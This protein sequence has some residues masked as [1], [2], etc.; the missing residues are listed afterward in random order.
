MLF[1]AGL[2]CSKQTDIKKRQY[3]RR[4]TPR[5]KLAIEEK[6]AKQATKGRV[7]DLSETKITETVR[8]SP[9]YPPQSAK[10]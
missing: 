7:E 6:Q 9:K 5:T 10:I 3:F 2:F 8:D 1:N 4:L